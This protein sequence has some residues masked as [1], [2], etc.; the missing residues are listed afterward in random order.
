MDSRTTGIPP[1]FTITAAFVCLGVLVFFARSVYTMTPELYDN[2][3]EWGIV[4]QMAETGD[5]S[6]LL[7]GEHHSR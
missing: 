3:I 6:L 1:K 5:L 7:A 4:K 2:L